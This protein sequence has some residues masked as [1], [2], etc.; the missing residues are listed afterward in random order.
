[1]L[2]RRRNTET[3]LST[4]SLP[5]QSVGKDSRLL[6]LGTWQPK[7]QL[8]ILSAAD[9]VRQKSQK[10][11]TSARRGFAAGENQARNGERPTRL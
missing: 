7:L 11:L 3:S 5:A 1:V 2:D 8:N 9:A 10:F 4:A 6:V